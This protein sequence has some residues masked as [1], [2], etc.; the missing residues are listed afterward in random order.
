MSLLARFRKPGGF[1]QLLNVVETCA[2][3]KQESLLKSIENE[4]PVTAN[5]V[6]IK[7]LSVEKIVAWSSDPLFEV[8]N[9]MP[10]KLLATFLKNKD[11][12]IFKKF[13]QHLPHLRVKALQEV[14]ALTDPTPGELFTAD[15]KLIETVRLL[16]KESVLNLKYISPELDTNDVKVA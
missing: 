13:T 15:M 10:E 9:R 6:R 11:E 12:A 8:A 2:P 7:M 5:L 16:E 3:P 1:Q 14:M 4:D